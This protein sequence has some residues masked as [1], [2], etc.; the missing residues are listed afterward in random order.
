MREKAPEFKGIDAQP[1]QPVVKQETNFFAPP[2]K[3]VALLVAGDE[4]NTGVG[5]GKAMI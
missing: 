4:R 1:L 5:S 2:A 3:V